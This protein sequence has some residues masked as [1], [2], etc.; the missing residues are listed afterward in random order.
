M[1]E[2]SSRNRVPST[3]P[4]GGLQSWL[5]IFGIAT[6]ATGAAVWLLPPFSFLFGTGWFSV[7]MTVKFTFFIF[8]LFR[9]LLFKHLYGRLPNESEAVL[10]EYFSQPDEDR[11]EVST[12]LIENALHLREVSAGA[13]MAPKADSVY[14]PV[15]KS[16][17]ELRHLFAESQLSRIIITENDSLDQILGYIHVQQMFDEEKEFRSMILPIAFV[18]AEM[19]VNELLSHFVR[20]RTNIACVRTPEGALG[21]IV[22]LEDALEELFGE[23]EDEH[24]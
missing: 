22:T 16:L 21:G 23:I 15:Y 17:L 3:V 13:C 8:V 14:F 19:P 5:T 10:L 12:E 2:S 20:T 18:P 4:A 1:D 11:E 24:D 9:R 7:V 6:V